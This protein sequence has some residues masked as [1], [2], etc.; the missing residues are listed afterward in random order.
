MKNLNNNNNNR[1]INNNQKSITLTW[2]W[3]AIKCFASIVFDLRRAMVDEMD[4]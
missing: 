1:S 3:S 4:G 2:F